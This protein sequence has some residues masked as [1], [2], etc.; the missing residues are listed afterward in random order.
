[1]AKEIDVTG[2]TIEGL[3]NLIANHR[4]RNATNLPAYVAGLRELESRLGRGLDFDK[5]FEII[6]QAARE[7]R[8][9]SYKELAEASGAKWSQVHYEIGGHLWRLVEYAHRREWPMLSAIVVNKPNVETGLMEPDTLAG[10][11]RAAKDLG[12]AI[13]DESAFL[14]EQQERVFE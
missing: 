11:L 13:T 6:R 4:A 5:S 7:Q 8:F 2:L 12:Y 3:K 10:F 9:L 14:R 1:M